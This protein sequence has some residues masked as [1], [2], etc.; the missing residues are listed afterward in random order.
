MKDKKM[1]KQSMNSSFEKMW[2]LAGTHKSLHSTLDEKYDA[3]ACDFSPELEF[4]LAFKSH[5]VVY[6]YS[7]DT[8]EE[9]YKT[10]N[11]E[12][13]KKLIKKS[14]KVCLLHKKQFEEYMKIKRRL[15]VDG[16]NTNVEFDP[17]NVE[18]AKWLASKFNNHKTMDRYTKN[19]LWLYWKRVDDEEVLTYD[20]FSNLEEENLRE[21]NEIAEIFSIE[22]DIFDF[23]TPLCKEY[24]EFNHL[25]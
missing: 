19:A 2:Y 8:F 5:T 13:I 22:T 3:I 7:L 11:L 4:L 17:T 6:I 23:E 21:G 25:L 15:E 18:F 10:S 9:E 1:A 16:I 14:R 24:K 20:E 12:I